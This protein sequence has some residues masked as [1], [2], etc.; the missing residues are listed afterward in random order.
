MLTRPAVTLA[1]WCAELDRRSRLVILTLHRVGPQRAI[2][3]RILRT[4][5]EYLAAHFDIVTPSRLVHEGI[6]RRTAMIVADDCH[7]DTYEHLFPSART[8][9]I[10]FVIAVPTAFFLRGAWLWFDQL[11]WIIAN[12]RRRVPV[13]IEGVRFHPGDSLGPLKALL[14]MCRPQ[15]RDLLLKTLAT[16]LGCPPI[17][18]RPSPYRPISHGHMREMLGSGLVELCA[19]TVTHTVL[20]A[21]SPEDTR[22]EL[23]DS[24][25]DLEYFA[26]APILAFCYPD[27]D[28]GT[29]DEPSIQAVR[30]AG[31]RMAFTSIPGV[32]PAKHVD[33]HVLKRLHIHPDICVFRRDASSV[34]TLWS[35]I[36]KKVRPL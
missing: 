24:K 4:H 1:A 8:L 35:L 25:R 22:S 15:A 5:L 26:S 18:D 19:H 10:P 36:R 9:G 27:G 33:W 20:T 30:E 23:R 2:T 32:N 13:E 21:L 14:K 6:R 12:A 7:A 11:D 29:F 17:P 31:F 3:S 16:T 34:G 28:I